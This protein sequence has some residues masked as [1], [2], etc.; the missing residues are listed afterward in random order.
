MSAPLLT[1]LKA[2][3]RSADRK[4]NGTSH[5]TELAFECLDTGVER[6]I[7]RLEREYEGYVA[8][9]KRNGTLYKTAKTLPHANYLT[10]VTTAKTTTPYAVCTRNVVWL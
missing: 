8:V 4:R 2:L 6:L 10:M 1:E 7:E 9:G 5:G 3:R